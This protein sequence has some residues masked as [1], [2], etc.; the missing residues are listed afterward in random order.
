MSSLVEKK[1]FDGVRQYYKAATKYI[2]DKFP[3]NDD[4]LKHAQFVEFYN[5]M[6]A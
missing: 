6:T 5:R 4:T 3:L 1:F 2:F